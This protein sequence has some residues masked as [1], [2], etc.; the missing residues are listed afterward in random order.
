[1]YSFSSQQKY[2][3]Y[4]E[5]TDMRKSFNGLSGLV[6]N[7][8]KQNPTNGSVFIFVNKRCNKMKL[9]VWDR[10][11]F[12]I[13]YKSLEKGTFE[14]PNFVLINNSYMVNWDELLMILEGIELNSIKRKKRFSFPQ[15]RA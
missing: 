7:E 10:N 2:Y 14:L 5:P 12:V 13:F 6:N 1:M 8:M 4:G 9:L 3:W 11:G 15:K